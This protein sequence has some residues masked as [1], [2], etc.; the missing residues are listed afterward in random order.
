[1]LKAARPNPALNH[2]FFVNVG[3]P[4][5]WYSRLGWS[6]DQWSRWVE[7]PAVHTWVAYL[8]GSPAGYAELHEQPG[9]VELAFFRAAAPVSGFEAGGL[10]FVPNR[11]AGPGS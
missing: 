3:R 2:F 7:D 5:R 9:A 8:Q 10:V 11:A 6:Y 4:W 1:M